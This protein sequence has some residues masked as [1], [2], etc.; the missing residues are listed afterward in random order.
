LYITQK[1]ILVI[2]C[3]V[4]DWTAGAECCSSYNSSGP[5]EPRSRS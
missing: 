5:G 3:D 1:I 2:C 4:L